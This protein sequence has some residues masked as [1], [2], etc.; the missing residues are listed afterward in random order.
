MSGAEHLAAPTFGL[1]LRQWRAQRAV[2]QLELALR[3]EVSQR[4]VSFLESGR[5]KPSRDMVLRLADALDVPLRHQNAMLLAAGFAPAYPERDLTAPDLSQVRRAIDFILAKQEPY[6]AIVADR[7]WN[8]VASNGAAQRLVG[9]L[10]G[11]S[12]A[13]DAPLNLMALMF[14]PDG[15]RQHIENWDEVASAMFRRAQAEAL[16]AGDPAEVQ[17]LQGAIGGLPDVPPRSRALDSGTEIAPILTVH[18]H[19]D[20]TS[21]RFFSTITTLGTPQD[22]TLQEIRI[23][24]FFPAD[25]ATTDWLDAAS[26]ESGGAP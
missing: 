16:A 26:G 14:D 1:A 19:K 24:S 21:L 6:P 17:K 9:F 7:F 20:G 11:A 2:S 15:L 8:L 10:L 5:A 13:E 23:E 4:H 22:V 25:Q 18:F 12:A 3:S